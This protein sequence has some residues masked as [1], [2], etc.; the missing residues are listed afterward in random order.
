MPPSVNESNV[1]H[2]RNSKA[3]TNYKS[4]SPG[5]SHYAVGQDG[6][7]EVAGYPS[8]GPRRRR[9]VRRPGSTPPP[10]SPIGLGHE[11]TPA[12]PGVRSSLPARC[13]GAYGCYE[14]L[15]DASGRFFVKDV[16]ERSA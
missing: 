6:W 3:L 8:S 11:I 14:T 1:K 12:T 16:E 15:P 13:P 7:E 2:H 10:Y 9:P 4:E 5:R